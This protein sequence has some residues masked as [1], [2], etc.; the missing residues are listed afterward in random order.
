MAS[1]DFS[2]FIDLTIY[3]D[4]PE[5]I[6]DEAVAYAQVALPEWTPVAGSIEDA[7]IQVSTYLGSYLGAA[8]NRVPNGV[9]EGLLKLFGIDR[10][11][12][13]APTGFA[14]FTAIDNSGYNIPAG[15]RVGYR[16]ASNPDNPIL[17]TFDTIQDLNISPGSTSG[18]VG[19][20]GTALVEYPAL[21]SGTVLQLYSGVAYVNSVALA[22]NLIVG[23]NPESDSDYLTRAISKLNSFTTASV[24]ASQIQ[25]YIL[26][27][28]S[29]AYR[30]KVYNRLNSANDNAS[31]T[32]T[33]GHITI[34]VAKAGGGSLTA[35]A[36]TAIQTDV[37]NRTVAGLTIGVK[38]P[39]IVSIS[40][41][42][43]ATIKSGYSATTVQANVNSAIQQYLHP[44]FW[45]WSGTVYQ[46]EMIALID[47]VEGVDRVVSVSMTPGSGGTGGAGSDVV[48]TRF[49]SLPTATV[50]VTISGL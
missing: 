36:M 30:V 17:Y 49:G 39:N 22:G 26:S 9:L 20:T 45:D 3:D 18:T 38:A 1:P 42:V 24:T 8:I 27:S 34:Y 2:E 48:F 6:Y 32:A 11:V 10:L 19:I 46:N 5:T 21:A 7:I 4:Q 33:N 43:N 40:V 23:Q 35:T 31:V 25:Q 13:V 47:R 44:N 50:A 29:D 14:Q 12:G 28:Y 16:D 15:T 37:A 41:A